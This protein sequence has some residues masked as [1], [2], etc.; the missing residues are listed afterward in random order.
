MKNDETKKYECK[1]YG[2]ISIILSV[3]GLAI[4][5]G[6]ILVFGVRAFGGMEFGGIGNVMSI[7]ISV[8]AGVVLPIILGIY[9]MVFSILQ[10]R[11]N[12]KA[13]GVIA[14]ILST[15]TILAGIAM[16]IFMFVF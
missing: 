1:K 13:I 16:I 8:I 11:L 3:I 2:K 9:G 15:I 6:I 7:I 5:I 10:I 4:A 12:R 14:V